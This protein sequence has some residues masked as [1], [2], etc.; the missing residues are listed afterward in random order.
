MNFMARLV[1][2]FKAVRV[3]QEDT[4]VIEEAATK[5]AQ[6]VGD[7]Y[8]NQFEQTLA[9]LMHNRQVGFIGQLDEVPRIEHPQTFDETPCD[10]GSLLLPEEPTEDYET[11]SRPELMREAKLLGIRTQRTS[12]A[13]ELRKKI[14]RKTR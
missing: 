14:I 7:I 3:T 11:W 13:A 2:F 9:D 10:D 1:G 6:Q 4:E 5:C 8:L 12:K